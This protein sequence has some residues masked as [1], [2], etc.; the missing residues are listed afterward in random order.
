[1]RNTGDDRVDES[2]W[3]NNPDYDVE[4]YERSEHAARCLVNDEYPSIFENGI[5]S[6]SDSDSGSDSDSDSEEDNGASKPAYGR[7]YAAADRFMDS[8]EGIFELYGAF[9][10]EF[11][12]PQPR[13]DIPGP[14]HPVPEDNAIDPVPPANNVAEQVARDLQHY[15][16]LGEE[17]LDRMFPEADQLMR[18]I[19][20][21]LNQGACPSWTDQFGKSKRSDLGVGLRTRD[22]GKPGG[23]NCCKILAKVKSKMRKTPRKSKKP[24]K[25]Q[26]QKPQMAQDQGQKKPPAPAN[27]V[28]YGDYLWPEEAEKLRGFL[29]ADTTPPGPTYD[30]EPSDPAAAPEGEQVDIKWATYLL[31]TFLTLGAAAKHAAELAS[32][33]T[34]GFNGVVYAVHATPNIVNSGNESA[35]IG[36]ILWSQVIGWM[37]QHFQKA[38]EANKELFR[39]NDGYDKK[40]DSYSATVDVPQKFS[41]SQDLVGFMN[42]NGVAVGWTGGFPLFQAPQAITA[43]ESKQAKANNKVSAPHEPGTWDKIGGWM[44]SHIWAVALLPAVAV[45]NFIPGVGEAADAAELAALCADSVEGIELTEV[46]GSSLSEAA[47]GLGQ[48]LKGAAKLKVA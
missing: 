11:R 2:A 43:E 18:E 7:A 15:I 33:H 34:K 22:K 1:M 3:I 30:V 4:L 48:L 20:G 13:D 8:T 5:P 35:A 14:D 37:Q 21:E 45:L 16:D 39:K 42:K 41:S 9:P 25:N 24:P 12:P 40:F 17:E 47:S 23:N 27:I 28:F 26:G 10:P 6:E 29:P 31:P 46:G 36:G 44:K 38:F 32:Q 19:L